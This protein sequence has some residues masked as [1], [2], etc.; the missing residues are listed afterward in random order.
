MRPLIPQ[1]IARQYQAGRLNGRFQAVALFAD[2]AGFTSLTESLMRRPKDGVEILSDVLRQVFVPACRA[3]YTHGGFITLFAGD[4]F[5]A[6]FPLRGKDAARH[7]LQTA[8][9]LQK[10]LAEQPVARTP[11]GDFPL[12]IKIGLATG[13]VRV[14]WPRALRL[15]RDGLAIRSSARPAPRPCRDQ[16]HG[17]LRRPPRKT[18]AS[19]AAGGALRRAARSSCQPARSRA[20]R[21]AA[22]NFC[23]CRGGFHARAGRVPRGSGGFPVIE[24]PEDPAAMTAFSAARYPG[25]GLR[26]HDQP[27]DFGEKGSVMLLLF[28]APTAHEND[29]QRGRISPLRAATADTRCAGALAR[30]WH[31]LHRHA[32]RGRA[33][34]V[35]RPWRRGEPGGT[36]GPA[37]RL[38]PG[39]D[40]RGRGPAH[41]AGL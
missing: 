38:G 29:S 33:L 15:L 7:A 27:V 34:R 36:P 41:R 8:L 23:A 25:R 2:L 6:L 20:W 12:A 14:S 24:E 19:A 26:L 35:R 18:R 22:R 40:E 4:G 11:V 32:R 28:G 9:L 37:R 1:P 31:D 21:S 30:R 3:V 10:T 13:M 16:A 39:L 5:T 17:D